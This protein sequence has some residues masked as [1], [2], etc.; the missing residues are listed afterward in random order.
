MNTDPI[1]MQAS[2]PDNTKL[3]PLHRHFRKVPLIASAVMIFLAIVGVGF[4]IGN[5]AIA[6]SFWI[7]LMP[8]YGVL[9]IVTVYYHHEGVNPWMIVRQVLHWLGIGAA[10]YLDLVFLRGAGE[11]TSIAA[12]LSSLLLLA[13]GCYLAG[14]YVEWLFALVGVFLTFTLIVLIAAQEYMFLLVGIGI[15][16][17]AG[18]LV[19]HRLL[20]RVESITM[21]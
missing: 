11:Q 7:A 6:K 10:I 13:L 21:P 4:T 19:I 17:L 1:A 3:H 16:L 2:S 8:I 14:V 5:F 12:G 15:G 20:K 18:M 9:C